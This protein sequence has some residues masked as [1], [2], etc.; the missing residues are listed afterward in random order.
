VG[1]AA[2]WVAP[3]FLPSPNMVFERFRGCL[4]ANGLLFDD[5][6]VSLYRISVGF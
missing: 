1:A 6:R 3:L 2:S 5:A 4:A